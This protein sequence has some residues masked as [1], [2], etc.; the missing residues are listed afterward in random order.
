MLTEGFFSRF[1]WPEHLSSATPFSIAHRGASDH[2]TE[3]TLKAFRLAAELGAHMWE[4]DVR[5]TGDDVC[6]V[7]HD[8]TLERV[9]GSPIGIADATAD[10]ICA[11]PLPEGQRVPTLTEVIALAVE[12]GCGLYIELKDR[13]SGPA[14]LKELR[15]ARFRFAAIGAFD[16]TLGPMIASI[17]SLSWYQG[18]LIL[19]PTAQPPGPILPIYA[20]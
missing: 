5:Q 6:V 9:A 13:K 8:A 14:A 16:P 10:K 1:G 15:Q 11:V 17:R 20:G 18:M 3:N 19:L 12:V 2:A 4:L 7:H